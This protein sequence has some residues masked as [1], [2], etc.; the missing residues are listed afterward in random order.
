[1]ILIIIGSLIV[2]TLQCAVPFIEKIP[3]SVLTPMQFI[4]LKILLGFFPILIVTSFILYSKRHNCNFYNKKVIALTICAILIAGIGYYFYTYLIKVSSPGI[5]MPI[6]L[7]SIVVSTLF[8]DHMF[9]KRK[10]SKRDILCII[11]IA[12][13][14][15]F[16][17]KNNSYSEDSIKYWIDYLKK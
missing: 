17:S 16:L 4:I 10:V 7:S 5:I 12:V 11:L 6:I 13:S 1:M 9:F 15:Y 2:G 14:I 8:F 3:L